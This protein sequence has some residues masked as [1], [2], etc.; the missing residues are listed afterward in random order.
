MTKSLQI[1]YFLRVN[2]AKLI[3][4]CI[5]Y[6]KLNESEFS[7]SYFLIFTYQV[8]QHPDR[9]SQKRKKAKIVSFVF[10]FLSDELNWFHSWKI[11]QTIFNVTVNVY[12]KKIW[13]LGILSRFDCSSKNCNLFIFLTSRLILRHYVHLYVKI[14]WKIVFGLQ[15]LGYKHHHCQ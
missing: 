6:I 2:I 1:N 7:K 11:Y 10:R 8:S 12:S 15:K 5:T 13:Q 9:S 4:I 14:N 3:Q